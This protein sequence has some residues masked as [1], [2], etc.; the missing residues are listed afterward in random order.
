MSTPQEDIDG[1]S[2]VGKSI[3]REDGAQKATGRGVFATDL[4]L[5]GML[6]GKYHRSTMAHAKILNVD[7]SRALKVRG[8]KAIV[9]GEDCPKDEAGNLLRFGPYMQDGVIFAHKKARYIGEPIAAIAAS[10]EDAA[11]EASEL[12]E[13]EYEDLPAVFDPL[14]AMKPDAP[15]IHED[16]ERYATNPGLNP[17]RSGNVLSRIHILRGDP[18]RAFQEADQVV[19]QTFRTSSHHQC[20]MEPH[21][22]VAEAEPGGKVTVW[23]ST[24][25][26]ATIR[27]QLLHTLL[28]LPGNI[29]VV[30]PFIGG[31]FGG[32]ID[33]RV[34]PHAILLAQRTGC[35]V[36]IVLTREEE[37]ISGNPRHPFIVTYKT[38]AKK[39]GRMT[40]RHFSFTVDSGAY[41][42]H[43]P[44]VTEFALFHGQGPYA[45]PNV[46]VEAQLVYTNK[47]PFGAYRGYGGP[48]IHF[49]GESQ[50][51]VLA[52][53]LGMDP[54]ELRMK[55]AITDRDTVLTGQPVPHA[56]FEET[57][58]RA[59]ES[60]GWDWENAEKPAIEPS[61]S[62]KKR[63]VGAASMQHVSAI[64][65][66]GAILK[67]DIGG[68]VTILTGGTEV[69]G[70]QRTV[71]SQ[72]AAEALGVPLENVSI[73]MSDTL[74]TAYDW[75]TD[76][77][78]T[79]YNTG[80]AILRAASEVKERFLDI[81]GT[82]LEAAP[83]DLDMQDGE[84]WVRSAPD[85][86]ATYNDV[87]MFGLYADGG[88]I[89]GTGS[90][91]QKPTYDSPTDLTIEGWHDAAM[92]SAFIYATQIAEVEVDTETGQ[93]EVI[94]LHSAHDVG[95]AI[96]PE[97]CEGQIEGA[98]ATGIGWLL[99]EEMVFEDGA[100]TNPTLVDYKIPSTL[101]FAEVRSL[102]V[103]EEDPSGPFGAKGI[104]EPALVPTAAA[105]ANAIYD[106]IGVRIESMPFTAD[107]ILEALGAGQGS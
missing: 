17:I 41:A 65:T 38:G 19:E 74:T 99:S 59:A 64:L 34:E 6:Y 32:K 68:S 107:R 23:T 36:K 86:R 97:G 28:L 85:R 14:E 93:V 21:A 39:D 29:R 52:E 72:I 78:R 89:M 35:P 53:R 22:A 56:A 70:G 43:G 101:D 20:Y 1:F 47:L 105:V 60:V 4:N 15:I 45:I 49:A 69:G 103:E 63:G 5:P 18:D 77:S 104:G 87:V 31:G 96:S 94:A 50:L 24:Q 79:T 95:R 16:L 11:E 13:V 100:V 106:A 44:G 2:W 55:N 80:N 10:N 37:F 82:M 90:F 84:V 40:A 58:R 57:L 91:F 83:E 102:L 54:V 33:L 81:A 61:G 9:T 66:S 8:V 25:S 76:A 71:L 3:P 27:M 62:R 51:D 42:T 73:V 26:V 75:A 92:F 12:I 67:M 88:A 30:A 46:R 48:Q 7:S 98:A